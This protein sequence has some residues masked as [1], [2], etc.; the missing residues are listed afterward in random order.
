MRQKVEKADSKPLAAEDHFFVFSGYLQ[1]KITI[2]D[3]LHIESI[4]V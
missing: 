4:G 3:I 2:A 1:V